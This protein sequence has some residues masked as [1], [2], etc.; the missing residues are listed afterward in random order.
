MTTPSK[1]FALSETGITF[2]NPESNMGVRDLNLRLTVEGKNF[3]VA[4][5]SIVEEDG[6]FVGEGSA[7]PDIQV[8]T[9]LERV[10]GLEAVIIRHTVRNSAKRP[11]FVNQAATGQF[12][13][14]AAVL[15]GKG[16]WLGLDLRYAHTDNVRTE[17][18]PH[19]QME[20]PYGS[21]SEKTR[22]FPVCS[23]KTSAP[24]A[25]L[26]LPPLHRRRTTRPFSFKKEPW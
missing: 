1:T 16:N 9:T 18:Y 17:R 20:Y 26:S 10:A 6:Q 5:A 22:L 3:D 19:C 23:S 7:G 8:K 4:Y 14:T 25:G 24:E 13:E 15:H 21:D 12:A 11:V 2:F